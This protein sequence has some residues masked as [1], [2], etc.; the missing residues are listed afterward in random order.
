MTEIIRISQLPDRGRQLPRRFRLQLSADGLS[1]SAAGDNYLDCIELLRNLPGKRIVI[2][3]EREG[4]PQ[5]AKIFYGHKHQ[6]QAAREQQGYQLLCAS[7][8]RTPQLLESCSDAQHYS[9]LFYEFL[10]RACDLATL[11]HASPDPVQQRSVLE[12]VA[13]T[14]RQMHDHQVQ[15]AD[16]HL[17]NFLFSNERLYVIDPG[18]VTQLGSAQDKQANVALLIAQFEKL[19]HAALSELLLPLLLADV[20]QGESRSAFDARLEHC[21][22]RRREKFLHK[23][24]RNCS[25]VLHIADADKRVNCVRSAYDAE[26]AALLDDPD[27][28]ISQSRL[29]KD[30]NSATVALVERGDRQWVV[31][32]YNIKNAWSGLKRQLVAT[33]ARRSWYNAHLLGMIGVRTP[34]PIAMIE[35]RRGPFKTTAYYISAYEPGMSLSEALA[36]RQASAA[37]L[38]AIRQLFAAFRLGQVVHGDCKAS[39]FIV[40]NAGISVLD[41]DAMT[42]C[43]NPQRFAREHS[44]DIRRFKKN[45]PDNPALQQQIA[46]LFD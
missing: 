5:I 40:S 41:L 8:V 11:W 27:A 7:D 30:G 25:Y 34:Q 13:A 4:Q 46:E 39:N 18:E 14:I 37:E 20:T 10:D 23:I 33:R 12:K 35:Q 6:Q 21:W 42:I 26:L 43:R 1:G 28:A 16:L 3:T 45:W 22:Q 19:H 29:L 24:F 2:R 32:R 36:G 31:K 15:Q 44:Q 9:V 17:N 38:A